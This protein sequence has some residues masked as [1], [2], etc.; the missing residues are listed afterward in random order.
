MAFKKIAYGGL[1][2]AA[3]LTLTLA[4]TPAM[5]VTSTH[6]FKVN[7][8]TTDSSVVVNADPTSGD[9][10]GFLAVTPDVLL[11]EGQTGIYSYNKTTLD[12][13]GGGLDSSVNNELFSDLTTEIAYEFINSG[14]LLTGAFELDGD[15]NRTATELTF[16][17]AIPINNNDNWVGANGAGQVAFWNGTTGDIWIVSLPSGTLTKVTGKLAFSAFENEP[18]TGNGEGTSLRQAGI[19][20]FDCVDYSFILIDG[21][22][23]SATRYNATT[24]TTE[25]V[26]PA[27]P[28]DR[29]DI[30]T[31]MVSPSNSRWYVH[32]ENPSPGPTSVFGINTSDI[33]EPIVS[34]A[35]T[36]TTEAICADAA[37]VLP[38]TGVGENPGIWAASA[39][40]IAGL[41]VAGVF[42]ARRRQA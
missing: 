4:A 28:N 40:L 21:D 26:I 9:D 30:D 11:R 36:F 42:M 20:E 6:T 22:T 33:S 5:A 15:G 31:I 39:A 23:E 29:T 1:A 24:G 10:N 18:A 19:L 12:P 2:L 37:P 17:E 32:S 13:I 16:T 38:D 3:G 8:M 34:G 25:V 41:G 27:G 7:T 35:A 14:G